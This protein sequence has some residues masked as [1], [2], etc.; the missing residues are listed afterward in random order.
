MTTL[1]PP[2]PSASSGMPPNTAPNAGSDMAERAGRIRFRRAVVLLLM[3]LVLP[4]SAQLVAGRRE[5]GRIALRV[6]F[7]AVALIALVAVVGVLW[8]RSVLWAMTTTWLLGLLRW[9][10]IA[11]AIGWA[12]LFL[13]AWRLGAPL[14]LARP[15][16]LTVV[17]INGALCILVA[18]ALLFSAHVVGVQKDFW[19]ALAG[20]GEVAGAVDGRFNILLAGADAG[21]GRQGLRPDSLT[22]ASIDARTGRTVLI[23]LPRNMANFPFR[24]GSVMDKQFPDG[25][26]CDGCML[27]AV[28]T[29]AE[30]HRDLFKHPR[31][32]GMTATV[33]A[34]EGI[35]GL[36]I[37]YWAM[38]DMEGFSTLVDAFGGVELHLRDRI[39]VGLPHESYFHYME[40]GVRKLD[41]TQTLWF[42]RARHG[43]DDYSRMARQKCVMSAM[44]SQVSP[45]QAVLNIS[46]IA[47]AGSSMLSTNMPGG[48]FDR[49]VALA[50]KAKNEKMSSVSLVPPLIN[51]GNPDMDVVHDAVSTAIETSENPPAK[52]Q[53]KG[54]GKGKNKGAGTQ[55]GQGA[56]PTTQPDADVPQTG[57]SVGTM[58]DGY[59]ANQTDDVAA[60]C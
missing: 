26:N 34:V 48:E 60:V 14:T 49:F 9:A 35:T 25:F 12:L 6:W 56:E 32:A 1:Q 21:E 59:A 2:A 55:G 40:P 45:Q 7:V 36:E 17:G 11:L 33:Q 51:T 37:S 58:K 8:P 29:W 47:K 31:K 18:G 30:D 39:P 57:G 22:V 52:K 5:V 13:D 38:V 54:G 43:S 10:L 27:N 28:S 41:G 50:L 24:D 19:T 44:L 20:D 4:G 46:D 15:Q 23:G 42:S 16:R 53:G 3:T